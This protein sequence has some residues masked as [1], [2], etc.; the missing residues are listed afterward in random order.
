MPTKSRILFLQRGMYDDPQV[1]TVCCCIG[2]S[3]D[4]PY[5]LSLD[6][7]ES[8]FVMRPPPL[9]VRGITSFFPLLTSSPITVLTP[10][11]PRARLTRCSCVMT[12]C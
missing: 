10:R 12:A 11:Y 4:T 6:N 2:K 7:L 1:E 3:Q 9:V 5:P 8:V